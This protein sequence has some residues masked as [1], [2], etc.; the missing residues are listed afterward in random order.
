[1]HLDELEVGDFIQDFVG[2]LGRPT[3]LEGYQKVAVV[4]GGVAAPSLSPGKGPSPDGCQGGR[5]RGLSQQGHF[6]FGK[7]NG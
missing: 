4:G 7:G 2:P 6:D 1:M 5:D 3:E